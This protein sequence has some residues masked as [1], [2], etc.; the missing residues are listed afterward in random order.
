MVAYM[1]QSKA[2][3]YLQR[4]PFGTKPGLERVSSL[5]ESLGNP[6][7]HLKC[8]H[9]A[10]TNGKGSFCAMLSNILKESRLKTGQFISPDIL[11][12]YERMQINGKLITEK[13]L[14]ALVDKVIPFVQHLADNDNAPTYF[15]VVTA[16][17]F[18]WFYEKKVDVVVLETGLG[19]RLDATN[20]IETPLVSV[21]MSI[22]MDHM[23]WLGNTITEIAK[24]K[25]G[26]IKP[27]G[28]VVSYCHQQ[29]EALM[30]LRQTVKEKSNTFIMS[31]CSDINILSEN[32]TGT[33]VKY[34]DLTLHIPLI[35][36]HQA[37]NAL[38]VLDTVSALRQKDYAISDEAIVQGI[39]MTRHPAR[40][41]LFHTAPAPTLLDGGHNEEG[42]DALTKALDTYAKDKKIITVMG[43]LEDKPY[44]YAGEQI[45]KRSDIFI[46]TV[47]DSPRVVDASLLA[48]AAQAHVKDAE[49]IENPNQALKR[50]YELAN[51]DSLVLV[52]GSLYLAAQLREDILEKQNE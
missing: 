3:S 22:S 39:Q 11:G 20:V 52:C 41:E 51:E 14:G 9:V 48:K 13:E 24:E 16:I 36:G 8:I 2:I 10:G 43:M 44:T 4:L 45:A 29:S 49:V 25:A 18:Q 35:G 28:T 46:A 6:Q 5:L 1:Q 27:N 21:V 19:G 17:A 32:L 40:L 7:K 23:E 34:H 31:P 50:A 15:E 38:T 33:K 26:I 37:Y 42:I 12:F 47:P 30:I